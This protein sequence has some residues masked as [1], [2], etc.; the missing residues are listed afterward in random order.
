MAIGTDLQ[1]TL[2]QEPTTL[3][4]ARGGEKARVTIT[5]IAGEFPAIPM[6]VKLRLSFPRQ[7]AAAFTARTEVSVSQVQAFIG[8]DV[9]AKAPQGVGSVDIVYEVRT[10]GDA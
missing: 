4:Q 5:G 9:L 10:G 7:L 2:T 8:A 6:R 3:H 1:S